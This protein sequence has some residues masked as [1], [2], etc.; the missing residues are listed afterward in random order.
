MTYG[1]SAGWI[2]FIAMLALVSGER[3]PSAGSTLAFGENMAPPAQQAP[4][5]QA[6]DAA[7][8]GVKATLVGSKPSASAARP[9]VMRTVPG[10]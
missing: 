6:A 3:E 9:A 1:K 7:D 10:T 5:A 2:L 8:P 4:H